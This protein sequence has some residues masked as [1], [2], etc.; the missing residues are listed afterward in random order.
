MATLVSLLDQ[1]TFLLEAL[2]GR[3]EA[4][5]WDVVPANREMS[6]RLSVM[7]VTNCLTVTVQVPFLP[8]PS[9][10]VQVMVQ[11]PRE[12]AVTTPL[13]FTIATLSSLL[14]HVTFLFEALEGRIVAVS[15]DVVPVFRLRVDLESVM[16]V[17]GCVT[18]TVQMAFLPL[19]SVAAQVIVQIPL[20]TAVIK[21]LWL[22]VAT[23]E[24]LLVHVTLL[25]E[26]VVG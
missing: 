4:D 8:L 17:T 22:T 7:F 11:V 21:P 18:E 20:P 12:T 2:S 14:V 3:T 23:F 9:V 25:L 1:V 15:W 24:S 19:P 6:D 5:N 26:A 16:P 10:A 13:A